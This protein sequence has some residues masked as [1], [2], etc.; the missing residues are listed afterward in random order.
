MF[1]GEANTEIYTLSLHDT[2]PISESLFLKTDLPIEVAVLTEPSACAVHCVN[3]ANIRFGDTVVVQGSGPIGLLV[4]NWA[5]FS[6]A[7]SVICVGGP[8]GRL[9]MAER[10]GADLTIDIADVPDPNASKHLVRKNTPQGAGDQKS[11][12]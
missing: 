8:R 2:V 7:A 4:L 9:E 10:F 5:R 11:V 6:G 1:N 12:A 3:R